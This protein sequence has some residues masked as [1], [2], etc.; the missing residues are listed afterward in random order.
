MHSIRRRAREFLPSRASL[1]REWLLGMIDVLS[2]VRD[3][4]VEPPQLP[5][6]A[7]QLTILETTDERGNTVAA[8]SIRAHEEVPRVDRLVR[9]SPGVHR[10]FVGAP[11][12]VDGQARARDQRQNPIANSRV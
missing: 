2:Y 4:R 10:A 5:A 12:S 7:V 9:R 3:P 6:S 8:R 11:K 1:A